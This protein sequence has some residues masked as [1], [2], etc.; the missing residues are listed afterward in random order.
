VLELAHEHGVAEVQIGSGGIESRFDAQGLAGFEGGLKAL[1]QIGDADD[2]GCAFLEQVKLFVDGSEVCH[3]S[4]QYRDT[5]GREKEGGA[6]CSQARVRVILTGM[7]TERVRE[8]ALKLPHVTEGVNWGSVLVFWVGD[9]AIGGKMFATTYLEPS[10]S[11]VMS[12]HAGPERF[13]ELVEVDGFI[14]APYSARHH[15]VTLQRW[16]AVSDAELKKLIEQAHALIFAKLPQKTKDVLA[17]EPKAQKKVIAE[18][19]KLLKEREKREVPAK[20]ARTV[21]EPKKSARKPPA[22]RARKE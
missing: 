18:R 10:R 4:E 2:F 17:M 8:I 19:K 14:P 13:H 3:C 20:S 9:K 15:W 11:G 1:A 12:L 21:E 22:K 7:D 16:N 5:G 6:D